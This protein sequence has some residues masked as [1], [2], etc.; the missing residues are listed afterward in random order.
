L[1]PSDR[2]SV[3]TRT[4]FGWTRRASTRV[5]RSSAASMPVTTSTVTSAGSALRSGLADVFGGGDETAED[6]RRRT[7]AHQVLDDGDALRELRIPR[8]ATRPRL[9]EIAEPALR[10]FDRRLVGGGRVGAWC[11]VPRLELSSSWSRDCPPADR[12]G[13]GCRLPPR[14]FD[15]ARAAWRPQQRARADRPEE[16][17]DRPPPDA[18]WRAFASAGVAHDL[19]GVGDDAVDELLVGGRER[20]GIVAT[21]RSG[22][23]VSSRR[24][25]VMSPRR[26]WTRCRASAHASTGCSRPRGRP[27]VPEPRVEVRKQIAKPASL[28]ECGRRGHEH[29]VALEIGRELADELRA[30][31]APGSRA[32]R[33]DA[34]VGLVDD[35]E[36]RG[37]HAGSRAG[38]ARS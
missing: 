28:P 14:R 7:R 12:V 24:S 37:G 21:I 18:W 36:L 16:R 27:G 19:A 17:Q 31:V 35:H 1:M 22:N 23:G 30:H 29:E 13:L 6:D 10:R 2:Q 26:R 3:A 34:G 11:H 25:L 4:R 32:A 15:C 5:R 33:L 8:P 20:V 38:G 9:G